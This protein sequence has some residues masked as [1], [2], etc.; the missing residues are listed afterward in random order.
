MNALSAVFA[1]EWRRSLTAGRV[2]WWIL[3][4]LFPITVSLLIRTLPDFERN[5]PE[6]ARDTFWS[7]F[8]YVMI[9]CL[10]SALGV[11][12]TAGPAVAT[13]LEQR[14]WIYMATRPRGILWLLFG[15]FLVAFTWGVSAAAV[16]LSGSILITN[17]TSRFS[18]WSSMMLL[19]L[20]SCIAYSAAFLFVGAIFPKRAMVF[21]V[22]YVA[23]VEVVLGLIPAVVNRMTIQYRLRSLLVKW[24]PAD[25]KLAEESEIQYVFGNDAT[26]VHILWLLGLTVGYFLI[27]QIV[28]HW[29]EFT[30][31]SEGDL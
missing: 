1:Y 24:L 29:K 25:T 31:A 7:I 13:E 28:V 6:R 30:T 8:L 22:I 27:A 2:I 20:L 16:A 15:K 19:S 18:I 5:V 21:S 9:P 14:S 4:S 10:C 11:L 26:W 17:A 12:L 23:V 3:M